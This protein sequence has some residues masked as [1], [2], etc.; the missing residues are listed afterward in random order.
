GPKKSREPLTQ[1]ALFD[2]ATASLGRRAQT[3][4]ELKRK[5]RT[6][7]E[8]GETGEQKITAVVARLKEYR[9]LN[10]AGF[11]ADYAR[12]RQDNEKL[13]RRRVQQGLMQK[14]VHPELVAKTLD[15]AYEGVNEEELARAYIERKRMTQPK[16]KKDAARTM[17]RLISAGFTSGTVFK[18]MRNWAPDED[19][20]EELGNEDPS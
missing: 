1:A 19:A 5:M 10:D 11:A 3:V 17:R 14:G 7:V 16:D 6:R 2:Y 20:I 8:P 4:A 15:K 9:F 18:L 12:L 13:G